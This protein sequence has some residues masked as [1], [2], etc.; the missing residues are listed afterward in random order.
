MKLCCRDIYSDS[1]RD[2]DDIKKEPNL[3][4]KP[5][6]SLRETGQKQQ[7]TRVC[8]PDAAAQMI[9]NANNDGCRTAAI[10]PYKERLG[11]FNNCS[12]LHLENLV[13]CTSSYLS[14]FL[15]STGKSQLLSPSLLPPLQSSFEK[16]PKTRIRH[17]DVWLNFWNSAFENK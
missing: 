11:E 16:Q 9:G 7:H 5:K 12:C 3:F 8:V 15:S 17:Y 1:V 4:M 10:V 13:P 6:Q 2:T 14:K